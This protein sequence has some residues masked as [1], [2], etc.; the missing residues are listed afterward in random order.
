MATIT[1]DGKQ[2]VLKA[3]EYAQAE[4]AQ[5]TIELDGLRVIVEAHERV[6]RASV[7]N[8][9]ACVFDANHCDVDR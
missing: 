9:L 4:G 5:R 6:E 3:V 7:G 2:Y 8:A 1:I